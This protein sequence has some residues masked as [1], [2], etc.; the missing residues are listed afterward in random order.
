MEQW[1]RSS[2]RRIELGPTPLTLSPDELDFQDDSI[3]FSS[4][5]N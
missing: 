1:A 5:L 2:R 4:E 3:Y